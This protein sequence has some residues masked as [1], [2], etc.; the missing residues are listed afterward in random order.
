MKK[1]SHK[2]IC[3]NVAVQKY[4]DPPQTPLMKTKNDKKRIN[5]C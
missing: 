1:V 2:K 4:V 5:V 3:P